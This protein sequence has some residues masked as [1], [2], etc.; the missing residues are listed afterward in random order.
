MRLRYR[1]VHFFVFAYAPEEI[2]LGYFG[3]GIFVIGVSGADFE[4]DVGSNDSWVVADGFE[5][6]EMDAFL[7]RDACFDAGS[8]FN[9]VSEDTTTV[10]DRLTFVCEYYLSHLH[11]LS[12]KNLQQTENKNTMNTNVPS[13]LQP[14]YEHLEAVLSQLF[15]RLIGLCISMVKPI[16]SMILLDPTPTQ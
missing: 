5:E 15:P 16:S 11:T 1:F 3:R 14:L 4:R 7:F 12:K 9:N 6:D 13:I 10:Q 8:A 2:P